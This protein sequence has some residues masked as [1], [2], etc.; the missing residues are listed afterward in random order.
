MRISDW[1]SDVC[2]S[3]LSLRDKAQGL[4]RLQVSKAAGRLPGSLIALE[5]GPWYGDF[6]PQLPPPF[7]MR[8]GRWQ[9]GALDLVMHLHYILR[10]LMRRPMTIL[11]SE[12]TLTESYTTKITAAIRKDLRRPKHDK[13]VFKEQ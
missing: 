5:G 7:D 2:S 6:S 1:S 10:Q 9:R 12:S 11:E 8:D 3:D 13:N 4:R